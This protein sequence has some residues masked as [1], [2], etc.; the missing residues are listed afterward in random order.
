MNPRTK[1]MTPSIEEPGPSL[2]IKPAFERYEGFGR[3]HRLV[4]ASEGGRIDGQPRCCLKG[5]AE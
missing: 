1:Q 3:R 2:F 5:K 4:A